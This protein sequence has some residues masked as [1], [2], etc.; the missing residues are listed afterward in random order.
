T[1]P[2]LRPRRRRAVHSNRAL[3][4]RALG[5]DG[6]RVVAWIGVLLVGGVVLLV[7]DDQPETGHRREDRRARADDD[8]GL[9]ARDPLALVAALGV[10]QPGVQDRDAVAEARAD[11][12]DGLRRE[13]DL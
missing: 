8:A 11:A 2:A 6:A 4:R 13:R 9:A 7:D 1:R 3:E 5:R 12:A 10:G